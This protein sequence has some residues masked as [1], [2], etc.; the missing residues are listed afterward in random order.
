M[1]TSE[2]IPRLPLSKEGVRLIDEISDN[3]RALPMTT[4]SS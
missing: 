2:K 3:G 1:V 4:T